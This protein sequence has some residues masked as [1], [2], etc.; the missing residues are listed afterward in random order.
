MKVPNSAVS[1]CAAEAGGSGSREEKIMHVQ[2]GARAAANTLSAAEVRTHP[3]CG[4]LD[5]V[6]QRY[7]GPH[8][9]SAGGWQNFVD[10]LERREEM[11]VVRAALTGNH[12]VLDVGGG[13]GEITRAVAGDLGRCVTVE[14]HV[15]RVERL[16]L[17]LGSTDVGEL[18][19]HP[20]RAEALPFSDGTFDA[21]FSAWVLPYVD[22]PVKAVREIARVCDPTHGEAKV[23]LI[24]GSP[25]NEVVA[26]LN[27]VCVPIAGE[28]HDH[29]GYLLATAAQTLSEHGFGRL[30]L[31]R[32]EAAL[33][34]TEP[35]LAERIRAAADLLVN[36]WYDGHPRAA[37]M[38]EALVPAL[39][40]HFA[41][42]PHA[43]GDQGL[44]LVA[45]PG[46]SA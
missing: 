6:P 1:G 14:P 43:I 36:F 17:G 27:E 12:Q 33:H 44:V 7:R 30:S 32:T 45:R 37:D 4:P 16:R 28:S 42:R 8:R 29:Q 41:R 21:V 11:A 31:S 3:W 40:R 15:N 20:G 35:S 23:V 46:E 38:R 34:F 39:N 19:V 9:L 24:G 25:D 10:R 22:N 5:R 26:L 13:T 2:Q 18:E